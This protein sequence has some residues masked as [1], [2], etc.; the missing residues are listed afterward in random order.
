[1]DGFTRFFNWLWTGI[2]G[3][4]TDIRNFVFKPVDQRLANANKVTEARPGDFG[5]Q[6][7]EK[8]Q[9]AKSFWFGNAEGNNLG[10]LIAAVNTEQRMMPTGA[11]VT[12][13][14]T[15]EAIIP[16]NKAQALLNNKTGASVT[17]NVFANTNANPTDIGF[18]VRQELQ[19]IFADV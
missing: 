5:D 12:I 3:V 2:T 9:V 8:L 14:N 7:R 11:S 10:N 18:A 13:A 15:S 4:F 16:Q 19:M 1:M 17:V 6:V